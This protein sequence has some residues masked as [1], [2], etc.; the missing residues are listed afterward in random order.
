M[1][2]ELGKNKFLELAKIDVSKY[3]IEREVKGKTF[4]YLPWSF[5][6]QTLMEQDPEANWTFHAP[7]L[8]GETMMV[9]CSVTAFGKTMREYLPVLDHRNASIKNPDA[10][11]VN[12]AQR[13]C[14]T[15]AIALH[16][17]GLHVYQ[18]EDVPLAVDEAVAGFIAD[19]KGTKSLEELQDYSEQLREFAEQYPQKAGPIRRAYGEKQNEFNG[20]KQ[21]GKKAKGI[22]GLKSRLTVVE[23]PVV[24]N[25]SVTTEEQ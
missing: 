23:S 20:G 12:N 8:Y 1:L 18:G 19:I 2:H 21:D 13:R 14:L 25:S 11:A 6:V 16:G 10:A 7:E 17:L 4:G 22:A 24:E 3:V 9:S 15:K 5:A